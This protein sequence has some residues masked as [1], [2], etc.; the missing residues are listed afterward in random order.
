LPRAQQTIR[1]TAADIF[2]KTVSDS[3]I[4]SALQ[5]MKW[6]LLGG[7][8]YMENTTAPECQTDNITI[9]NLPQTFIIC[10]GFTG[11]SPDDQQ[12]EFI[13]MSY[14]MYQQ[15][16]IAGSRAAMLGN[17]MDPLEAERWANFVMTAYSRI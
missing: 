1:S 5:R 7:Q 11:L 16:S 9:R 4:D 15:F 10:P 12:K 3:D 8:I 13:R 17:P 14:R 6:N 2:G